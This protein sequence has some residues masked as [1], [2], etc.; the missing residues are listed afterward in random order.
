MKLLSRV[1]WREGMHLSQHHFQAQSRYYEETLRVSVGQLFFAPY[2]VSACS[3]DD[4]ALK[5]GTLALR[6]ARGIMADGLPFHMP[7]SDALPP[8]RS[9]ASVFSP[10]RQSHVVFLVIAAY[11]SNSANADVGSSLDARFRVSPRMIRDLVT[12]RDE[13]SVD[14]GTKNFRLVLDHEVLPTDV[15]LPVARVERDGAGRFSFDPDFIPPC[16]KIAASA[17]V[18]AM[19]SAIVQ[20]CDTKGDALAAERAGSQQ[21]LANFATHEVANFWLLHTLRAS[22]SPLRHHL[23]TR[24]SHPERVYVDLVRLAGGLCTFTLDASPRDIPP[25]NHDDLSTCFGE[26]ERQL[27]ARLDVVV[28]STCI[29]LR[30][31]S[32]GNNLYSAAIVDGRSFGKSYWIVGLRSR[33]GDSILAPK[34]QELLKVCAKAFTMRLVREARSGMGIDYLP[35]PPS[36]LSPRPDTTYFALVRKGP[37]WDAIVKTREIGL[38]VPDAVATDQVDLLVLVED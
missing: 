27:R 6:H 34:T 5:N 15:A 14:I 19:L 7:E 25:Y 18:C 8:P 35:V 13:Q 22:V 9:I 12:G 38:Y 16:T 17:R 29:R 30:M 10:T 2:G 37:C 32:E 1:L 3:F 28:P 20:L 24:E 4:A 33:P 26:L 23:L 36:A 31:Q 21:D 11:S